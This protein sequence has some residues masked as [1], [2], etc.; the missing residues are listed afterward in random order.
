MFVVNFVLL[1][2]FCYEKGKDIC[3]YIL[4]NLFILNEKKIIIICCI[5]F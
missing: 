2:K 5:F 3:E 1:V 4:S